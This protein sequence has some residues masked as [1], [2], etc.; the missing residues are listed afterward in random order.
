M[1]IGS[2]EMKAANQ[3]LLLAETETL[4]EKDKD[5]N[6]NEKV[7]AM[8]ERTLDELED[9]IKALPE[10][11]EHSRHS[12]EKALK[13][14]R[15]KRRWRA[16]KMKLRDD[17]LSEEDRQAL[18]Q[19]L[20]EL[21]QV[22]MED[23]HSGNETMKDAPLFTFK[24]NYRQGVYTRGERPE[25]VH[26]DPAWAGSVLY[27]PELVVPEELQDKGIEVKPKKR[28]KVMTVTGIDPVILA[29]AKAPPSQFLEFN[30]TSFDDWESSLR[31]ISALEGIKGD[32]DGDLLIAWYHTKNPTASDRERFH[33]SPIL[34][35]QGLKKW[36]K[37]G[38]K[39]SYL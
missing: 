38:W 31:K 2:P 4:L 34:K 20:N 22:L 15:A 26:E 21:G 30:S 17:A 24:R 25:V 28:M 19:E 12:K 8:L 13:R 1:E 32:Y 37:V 35:R 33:I 5:L 6:D 18:K 39:F 9:A 7:Q 10:D 27:K 16:V 23:A 29:R 3:A 11:S 14:L 36:R